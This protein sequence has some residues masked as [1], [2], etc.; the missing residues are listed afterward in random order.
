MTL[1]LS[2]LQKAVEALDN[3]ISSYETNRNNDS[4]SANDKETLK[5]GVIQNFE[6][7]YELCWK[8]MKRWIEKNAAGE[9][10]DGFTMKKLFRI[11]S[12]HRLLEDVERWFDYY[13]ARNLTSHTYDASNAEKAFEAAMKFIHDAKALLRVLEERND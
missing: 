12:E 11:A 10:A 5:S 8:F 9:I 2:S 4:L 7:V 13:E 6:V 1:D 3:S